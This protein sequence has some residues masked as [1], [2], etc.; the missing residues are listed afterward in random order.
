MNKQLAFTLI[1]LLVV[2]A[3]IGILS[4][5]IVV[6]MSGTTEKATI[7]KGQIFSNSLRNSIMLNLVSEWKLDGDANDYWGNINGA[8]TGATSISSG[9][10]QGS[11]YSFDGNDY[12]GIPHDTKIK[13]TNKITIAVW[14]YMENWGSMSDGRLISCTETGG[15]NIQFN[16][17]SSSF[18][19]RVNSTYESPSFYSV[20]PANG[21]HYFVGTYD[22]RYI[23]A[24]FDGNLTDTHD[25]GANYAITYSVDNTLF[26]GAEATTTIPAAPYLIGKID[27]FRIF[28]ES[29]PISQIKE[30]YYLGLNSML[31]SRTINKEEY[32]SRIGFYAKN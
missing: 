19:V 3:V 1:E 28:N 30:Q 16:A 11:C 20:K 31:V 10:V 17:N 9:C 2:I 5:L 27:E 14:G 12:I 18:P 4:G 15:Y 32:L 7:A 13:P 23:R 21:W 25:A 26:V 29:V 24:Y 22:G 8:I 6:S